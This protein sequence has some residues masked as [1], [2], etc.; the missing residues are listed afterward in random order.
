MNRLSTAGF[1]PP[2]VYTGIRLFVLLGK[3]SSDVSSMLWS[4]R[5]R[6]VPQANSYVG[7]Q[8]CP[9][10]P[11]HPTMHPDETSL[12]YVLVLDLKSN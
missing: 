5:R 12:W 2:S 7:K 10:P 8:S 9:T 6:I 3:R 1:V 4:V 11:S